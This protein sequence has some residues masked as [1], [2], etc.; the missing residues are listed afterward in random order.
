MEKPLELICDTGKGLLK[1]AY[2][3]GKNTDRVV[4]ALG[5]VGLLVSMLA[6]L[7]SIKSNKKLSEEKRTFLLNQ[8]MADGLTNTALFFGITT[9][10][11]SFAKKQLDTG[12]LLTP[13]IKKQIEEASIRIGKSFDDIIKSAKTD[14]KGHDIGEVIKQSDIFIKVQEMA[15]AKIPKDEIKPF[16]AEADTFSRTR[17]GLGMI[18]TVFGSILSTNFI[19]PIVRN[20]ISNHMQEKYN[21]EHVTVSPKQMLT[22]SIYNNQK[23]FASFSSITKI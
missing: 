16:Q 14:K 12:K 21:M 1:S 15:T 11:S 19:S 20:K 2:I 10:L 8:E 3:A 13:A 7:S 22:P 9:L 5:A 18:A 17:S 4:I 23:T 6:Q